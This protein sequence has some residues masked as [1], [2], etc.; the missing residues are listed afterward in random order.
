MNMTKSDTIIVRENA[1][2]IVEVI[3]SLF[4]GGI[5]DAEHK[6]AITAEMYGALRGHE[7]SYEN[8]VEHFTNLSY[9]LEGRD[10]KL[11]DAVLHAIG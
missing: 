10:E 9:E 7:G 3:N 6:N 8:L 5:I 2:L 11:V 1:R 4:K